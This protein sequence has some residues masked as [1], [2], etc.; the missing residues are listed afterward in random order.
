MK[1]GSYS[2]SKQKIRD[3][4]PEWRHKRAVKQRAYVAQRRVKAKRLAFKRYPDFCARLVALQS[5]AGQ[6]G[7]MQAV[8]ALNTAIRRVGFEIAGERDV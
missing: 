5:E 8:K 2:P 4:D 1:T 6:L 7:L 3:M